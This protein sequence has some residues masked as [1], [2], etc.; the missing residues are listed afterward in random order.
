MPMPKDKPGLWIAF[1][2]GLVLLIASMVLA[3][4]PLDGWQGDLFRAINNQSDSYHTI[5]L[6]ITEGLGA[7]C[8]IA[9]CV[10]IPLFMKKYRLAWR[11]FS[12]PARRWW[13]VL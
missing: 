10:L 13:L 5:S 7:G 8:A 1:F 12:R 3:A 9:A 2:A 6:W 4:N 11:F